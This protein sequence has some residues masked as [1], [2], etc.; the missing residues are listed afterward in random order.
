MIKIEEILKVNDRYNNFIVIDIDPVIIDRRQ[1]I[2]V[3]CDC[4]FEMYVR[5]DRLIQGRPR[6]CWICS[7]IK[8]RNKNTVFCGDICSK[9]FSD[10][11]N[12]AKYRNLE[13]NISMEYIW[14]LFLTQNKKCALTG[15]DLTLEKFSKRDQ[16]MIHKKISASLDRINSSL[17]YIEG[18]V[19][20]VHK[21]LNLM[22]GSMSNEMFIFLCN[23][24][25]KY[26]NFE[27]DNLE[28]SLMQGF[29]PRYILAKERA[30]KRSND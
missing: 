21:E 15:L 29:C 16:K 8:K 23:K 27:Y 19:Q 3:K 13:F 6:S 1:Q 28:P 11:K 10:I 14:N 26:H 7:N 25:A 9:Y 12:N 5:P 24:V 17:G 4:G 2:R 20:W 30:L 18:N 22:K